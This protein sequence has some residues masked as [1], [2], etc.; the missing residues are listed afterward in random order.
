MANS[1]L[2]VIVAALDGT[3]QRKGFGNI[4]NLLP[5]A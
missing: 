1:G 4:L 5:I 2:I 3:F